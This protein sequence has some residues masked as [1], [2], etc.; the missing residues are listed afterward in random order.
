MV[1]AHHVVRVFN[2]TRSYFPTGK[3]IYGFSQ[4]K[5]HQ[6]IPATLS[7][8]EHSYQVGEEGP[9]PKNWFMKVLDTIT[10]QEEEKIVSEEEMKVRK[11]LLE[12]IQ[13]C[14]YKKPPEVPGIKLY[15]ETFE[16]LMKYNDWR[17]V[18]QLLELAEREGVHL[19]DEMMDKLDD[20]LLNVKEKKRIW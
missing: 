1:L 2:R 3:L 8:L 13:A 7:R 18:E 20:Y 11:E 4:K 12:K 14:Y 15:N 17:G 10:F 6:L 5:G 19:E 16:M 9:K